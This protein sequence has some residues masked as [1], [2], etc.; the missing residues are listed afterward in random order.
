[1]LAGL[2]VRIEDQ[3]HNPFIARGFSL[4]VV[5]TDYV[6]EVDQPLADKAL[7]AKGPGYWLGRN[8]ATSGRERNRRNRRATHLGAYPMETVKRVDHPTTLILD[9]E[10]P[11]VSKR[12]AFF[13][14]ALRGDLGSKAQKERHRFAFKQPHTAGMM[15]SMRSMVPVQEL[16]L[17][18]I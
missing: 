11:R 2:N 6:L 14:R 16:S 9:D 4:A 8:G 3:L 13:D 7:R 17:I 10:V 15:A 18:H 12:A 1:M 5:T